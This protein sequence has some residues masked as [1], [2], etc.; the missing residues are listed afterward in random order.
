[1]EEAFR[2]VRGDWVAEAN[3]YQS[4]IAAAL[5]ASSTDNE[6]QTISKY[7]LLVWHAVQQGAGTVFLVR[8][9]LY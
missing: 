4:V 9:A 1:V 3:Q 7:Y 5:E 8:T 2:Q 6:H